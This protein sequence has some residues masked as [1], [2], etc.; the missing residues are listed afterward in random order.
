MMRAPEVH[1][2]PSIC[3]VRRRITDLMVAE[4]HS[5]RRRNVV[6]LAVDGV[7]YDCVDGSWW[8]A[9]VERLRS[10]F[11]TSSSPAWLSSLTGVGVDQHGVP[12]V[13]YRDEQGV[14]VN[15]YSSRSS[16]C[17]VHDN[18]FVD[19]ARV[20]YAP[21]VLLGDLAPYEC[22]WRSSILHGAR[23][24][25]GDAY[26]NDPVFYVPGDRHDRILDALHD[27][28]QA[29]LASADEPVMLWTHVELDRHLHRYGYD[30]EA[31]RTLLALQTLALELVEEGNVVVAH[32]DHGLT[33]TTNDSAVSAALDLVVAEHGAQM[34]GAGRTR[35]LYTTEERQ[36]L[37]VR[38]ALADALPGDIGIYAADDLFAVGGKAR[39]RVGDTLL[40]CHGTAF[41]APD[42]YRFDHGSWRPEELFVPFAVWGS[43]PRARTPGDRC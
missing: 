34:G 14:L 4:M 19:A 31:A 33:A 10:V 18:V 22:A 20:G 5:G 12:G 41:V 3:S 35:W 29:A 7:S 8:A 42:G 1:D 28:L 23:C 15:V 30:D 36:R 43:A 40:I 16:S 17:D 38:A 6:V 25:H 27:D 37:A 24:I 2:V 11:P 21:V 32:S 39:A 9:Q 13:I 26:F